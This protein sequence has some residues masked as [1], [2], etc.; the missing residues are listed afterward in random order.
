MS[1][2]IEVMGR[3]FDIVDIQHVSAAKDPGDDM[4]LLKV[5]YKSRLGEVSEVR[6][7]FD[8]AAE[9]IKKAQGY[10]AQ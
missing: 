8:A 3:G 5:Q 1:D 2:R 10:L 6:L 4:L 7:T 9:L